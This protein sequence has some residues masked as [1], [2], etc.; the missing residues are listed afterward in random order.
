MSS[1]SMG[2]IEGTGGSTCDA[3]DDASAGERSAATEIPGS[4]KRPVK[5]GGSGFRVQ[6]LGVG[7]RG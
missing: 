3:I 6:G 2:R 4:K 5:D 7:F 1:G